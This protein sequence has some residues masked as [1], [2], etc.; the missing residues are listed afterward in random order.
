METS[1]RWLLDTLAEYQ[2]RATFFVVGE[3]AATHPRAGP[4]HRTTPA[5][6]SPA[7]AG[8]TAASTGSTR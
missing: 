4:R 3:I 2:A 5:T 1:T 7:T 6:K 8:T